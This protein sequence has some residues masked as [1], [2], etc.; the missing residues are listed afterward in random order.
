[1]RELHGIIG[2]GVMRHLR[3][4]CMVVLVHVLAA[5]D[6]GERPK[7]ESIAAQAGMAPRTVKRALS[8]LRTARIIRPAGYE[9]CGAAPV[10][11]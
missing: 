2:R 5:L 8:E 1:M 3:P 4:R 9:L 7:V 6:R 11:R 10:P